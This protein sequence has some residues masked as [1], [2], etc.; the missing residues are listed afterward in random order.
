MKLNNSV[1]RESVRWALVAGSTF[2]FDSLS[3]YL[4]IKILSNVFTANSLSFVVFTCYNFFMHKYW[5]FQDSN[6]S[7]LPFL[8]YIFLL[9]VSFVIN[10]TLISIFLYFEIVPILSKIFASV[11]TI[12]LNYVGLRNFVFS[13]FE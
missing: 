1:N 6:S 8:R 13:K 9:V 3:F 5:T 11:I 2:I 7:H 10:S 12:L 4:L